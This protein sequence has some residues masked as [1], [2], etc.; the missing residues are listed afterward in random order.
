MCPKYP[1]SGSVFQIRRSPRLQAAFHRRLVGVFC[2]KVP[3][4]TSRT[5]STPSGRTFGIDYRVI[6]TIRT[7]TTRLFLAGIGW[8]VA[9]SSS[10]QRA[11]GAAC[12]GI[13][14]VGIGGGGGRYQPG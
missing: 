14:S 8:K 5:R 12:T 13:R 6:K 10:R 7:P 4:R 3:G 1:Y 2:S 11:I 9:G